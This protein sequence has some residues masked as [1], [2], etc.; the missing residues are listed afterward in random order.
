MFN[1]DSPQ[2]DES[3]DYLDF[4][5]VAKKI[6]RAIARID[7]SNGYVLGLEGAWGSGK[8][9]M[10]D[11]IM[12]ELEKTDGQVHIIRFNPWLVTGHQN[13]VAAYFQQMI[14]FFHPANAD[15]KFRE[16]IKRVDLVTLSRGF[17]ELLANVSIPIVSQVAGVARTALD[18]VKSDAFDAL[19]ETT[20]LQSTHDRVFEL[21]K[22]TDLKILVIIDDLD[23]LIDSEIQAI[24]QM[25]KSVGKLPGVTYLLAYDRS[26]IERAYQNIAT[27]N[28]RQKYLDKI[29]Q[30]EVKLPRADT[31]KLINQ[32]F[33][34]LS[35]DIKTAY[36]FD[37]PRAETILSHGLAKWLKNPR[38]V[39]RL[40]NEI[41]FCYFAIGEDVDMQDIVC[42]SGIKI[43]E[44]ELF[45]L[46]EQSDGRPITSFYRQE[47]NRLEATELMKI[48]F[49][50]NA[51]QEDTARRG[52]CTPQG[53]K[54]YFELNLRPEYIPKSLLN[55][56]IQKSGDKEYCLSVLLEHAS[57]KPRMYRLIVELIAIYESKIHSQCKLGL[58]EALVDFGDNIDGIEYLEASSGIGSPPFFRA[59]KLLL[60][61]ISKSTNRGKTILNLVKSGKSI[62]MLCALYLAIGKQLGIPELSHQPTTEPTISIDRTVFDEITEIISERISAI[63]EHLMGA[64]HLKP[65]IT[66]RRYLYGSTATRIWIES[67]INNEEFL[68]KL[69]YSIL[70][71]NMSRTAKFALTSAPDPEIYDMR[72]IE[73][74]CLGLLASHNHTEQQFKVFSAIVEG[75]TAP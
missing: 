34:S 67:N 48:L 31:I 66:T 4:V 20:S 50:D 53:W 18:Y 40:A 60:V 32:L 58:I 72:K 28:N 35:S 57:N 46:I 71:V 30:H 16:V 38:D 43:F 6:S 75:I 12:K 24:I 15:G 11:Y 56:I 10:I 41:S 5:P 39:I 69:C 26:I 64:R 22:N 70:S 44:P 14:E 61:L 8:S 19:S 74:A 51:G 62:S 36:R 63:E 21:L 49:P 52:I 54:T 29:I 25:V 3:G 2:A 7:S 9:T 33:A 47:V 37:D 27:D 45:S 42:M 65:L 68:E 1:N 17:A 23:R 13:L 55:N 59:T 73:S